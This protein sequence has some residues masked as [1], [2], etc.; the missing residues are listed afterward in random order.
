VAGDWRARFTPAVR[1]AFEEAVG[2]L[3]ARLGYA[4]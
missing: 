1:R 2:D 3:P 4:D